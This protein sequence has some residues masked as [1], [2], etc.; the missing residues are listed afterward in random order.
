MS[1]NL[2]LS[3]CVGPRQQCSRHSQ[4]TF[5]AYF[6]SSSCAQDCTHP[7]QS[8]HLSEPLKSG[9]FTVQ[10]WSVRDKWTLPAWGASRKAIVFLTKRRVQLAH[11]FCPL[12]FR[13][14]LPGNV[15]PMSG[16]SPQLWRKNPG[17]ESD[18]GRS[19]RG[20]RPLP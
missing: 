6:Q 17:T 14:F 18:Q 1:Q 12:H 8:K 11:V 7:F 10:V 19:C 13:F 16:G 9:M 2:A 5:L 3:W 4:P 15:D 20:V